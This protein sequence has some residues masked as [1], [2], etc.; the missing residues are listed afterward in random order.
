L[1]GGRKKGL[2]QERAPMGLKQSVRK[3]SQLPCHLRAMNQNVL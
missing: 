3:Q 2:K 1:F